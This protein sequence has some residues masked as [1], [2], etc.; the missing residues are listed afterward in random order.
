ME[1]D[2]TRWSCP[3]N[4]DQ[5]YTKLPGGGGQG[6]RGGGGQGGRGGELKGRGGRIGL[7]EGQGGRGGGVKGIGVVG[8]KG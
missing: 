3:W 6:G 2:R 5:N 4:S 7:V 8:V 1:F